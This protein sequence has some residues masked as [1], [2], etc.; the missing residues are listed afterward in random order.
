MAMTESEWAVDPVFRMR[1]RFWREGEDLHVETVVDPGGGATAHVHPAMTERF[2]VHEGRC[3]FLGGRKW[4]EKGPEDGEVVV[5]AGT[6]HGFRNRGDVPTRIECRATPP[7]PALQGFLE[8]AA[9]LS[10][11]GKLLRVGLPAPGGLLEAAVLVE[12]YSD[13]AVLGFPAPPR[14]IQKLIF[15]PLARIAARRG[16]RAGELKQIA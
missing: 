4:V 12:S 9:G 11:A 14:P 15:G 6:R 10:R 5:P 2:V 3:Q 1:H 13:M 8:D 7:D 16:L